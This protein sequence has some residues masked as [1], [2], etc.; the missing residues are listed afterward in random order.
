YPTAPTITRTTTT[1]A[2]TVN[3]T[4]PRRSEGVADERQHPPRIQDGEPRDEGRDRH[5]LV[6]QGGVEPDSADSADIA[7]GGPGLLEHRQIEK[8]RARDHQEDDFPIERRAVDVLVRLPDEEQHP[9]DEID[10]E[11]QHAPRQQPMQVRKR[12]S[13]H[14][15]EYPQV[16]GQ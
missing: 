5:G 2:H 16:H 12:D 7:T 10:A 1:T 6:S 15:P 8:V 14:Y 9:G 3:A 4:V 13:L 11:A